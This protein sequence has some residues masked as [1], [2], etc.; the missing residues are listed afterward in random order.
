MK[1]TFLIQN[2]YGIGGTNRT[3]V[4][5]AEGLARRHDVEIVSIFR[6]RHRPAFAIAAE[7]RVRALVDLRPAGSGA[8]HGDPL[9]REPSTLVPPEEEFFAQYSALTDERI[10]RHLAE[11]DADVVIG[12]RS[13]LN[14]LVARFAR[15][16]AL[17][18]AQEHMTHARIPASVRA[19]YREHYPRL[20]AITTV[21]EADARAFGALTPVPGVPVIAVPNS[22]AAPAI[23]PSDTSSRVIVAAGRLA[24]V[25]RYDLLIHAFA[26]LSPDFPDW[27]LRVYGQGG[28]RHALRELI[29]E[30]GLTD[31]VLLMGGVTPLDP[32]WV[33]GSIAAVT[34]SEESFGMTLVEAMR[35][36]L[37]VVSTDCPVGPREI[38]ADG[39][40]GLLVT[41]GD[42]E[43][44]AAGLRRLMADPRLRAAMGEAAER[45]ARRYDPDLVAERY[46]AL[47]RE[48]ADAR[49]PARRNR[50][51]DTVRERAARP[52]AT[53]GVNTR[54]DP[55]GS[56]ELSVRVPTERADAT[57][58]LREVADVDATRTIPLPT[59][60]VVESTDTVRLVATVRGDRLSAPGEGRWA[61]TL[62]TGPGRR[63]RVPADH[64]DVRALIGRR[65][66]LL[67]TPDAD[68]PF[69]WLVPYRTAQG[70]L[71]LRS[72]VRDGH[73][74]CTGV[75]VRT[76]DMTVHGVLFGPH[77]PGADT[78]LVLVRRGPIPDEVRAGSPE[79]DGRR[80]RIRVP[81]RACVRARLTR[82]EDWDW[83]LAPR[84][85]AGERLRV[86]R[87]LDDFVDKKAVYEYDAVTVA[88]ED[89][90]VVR[91][92]PAASL[93]RAYC[94]AHSEMSMNVIDR[95]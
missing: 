10:R 76:H 28:E 79:V 25:K 77:A 14:L 88:D 84:G 70:H 33:K 48:R 18:I 40:D 45:N 13:S 23:A 55:D 68:R 26:A 38:L 83:W 42:V 4:N 19:A 49:G 66:L 69:S 52:V 15:D 44:V 95:A 46:T 30:L 17:R 90:L 27:V 36:G 67:E 51:L 86:G 32:E 57:I 2:V 31:R 50:L 1:I 62:E 92:P 78:E 65:H 8:D 16:D 85:S 87:L 56:V 59:R 74:E 75:E 47:F 37:P 5:L 61:L 93:V 6:R 7:V 60:R 91:H 72:W 54:V 11:T 41:D 39:V 94:T 73:A 80:F 12:T 53:T 34:S 81:I 24:P 71:A 20:D 22:T 64:T 3:V 9:L 21:T 82:W 29:N 58:A 63:A 43:A 35:C 89:D